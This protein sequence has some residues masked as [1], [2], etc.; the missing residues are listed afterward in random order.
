MTATSHSPER[1]ARVVIRFAGD[2]GD[3]M[4]LTGTRFSETSALAGHDIATFPDFPAEIRAP[5]G[6][7][8]GVSGFQVQFAAEPVF[9]PGDRPDALVAMNPAALRR[10]ASEL[11]DGAVLI[12]DEDQF[13]DKN[14]LRAGYHSNPLTDGSLDRLRVFPV[15]ITRATV[16]AL[17]AIPELTAR[18]KERC[19]NFFALGLAYW[20]YSQSLAPTTRWIR[21][22]F[23]ETPVGAANLAALQKGYDYGVTTEI[24]APAIEV[25][26][27]AIAPGRYRS[28]TGNQATALGLVAAAQRAGR[29]LVFAGYPITPASDVLHDLSRHK[30]FGVKTLQVED[31]IAAACAAIGASYAG[32]IGVTASSGPGIALKGEAIGLAVAAELP[33][34]V[35]NVQRAGPSTGMP[36]KVEQ[37]DLNLALFGRNGESPV[38]IVAPRSPADAFETTV[39][40][41]RIATKYMIPVMY[42]SD[43]YVANGAEPWRIPSADSLP[44]LHVACDVDPANF[45]PYG[46]DP[47]TLARPWVVPGMPGLEHRIGGLEKADRTGHI[48]YDPANHQRMS[49][50]RA[51]KLE[52]IARDIP[53]LEVEGPADAEALVVSWGSTYGTVRVACDALTRAGTPVAHAHLRHLSPL[54]PN[55]EAVLRSARRVIA[56]ELNMGQ[57]GGLL[58]AR[59]ALDIEGVTKIQGQP[60]AV[61]E[62]VGRIGEVLS[63]GA[64]G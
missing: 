45:L 20:M 18:E 37:S 59:F 50:L 52:R 13:T 31:E 38:A 54:P 3:G 60:F 34:V 58:R 63:R 64:E 62:L 33:L 21:T 9:T 55:T 53:D 14:L 4:Q 7:L 1:R 17:E 19:R 23:G 32:A 42:L 35:V 5:A 10:N 24:F 2:S 48:S 15:A 36:T 46:R 39:E 16:A 41:V 12:C 22:K 49:E 51:E 11:D 56:A 28:I 57:L 43:A 25:P 44:D 6:S 27:A 8:G 40:A 29:E 30:T 26:A 61:A 47:E